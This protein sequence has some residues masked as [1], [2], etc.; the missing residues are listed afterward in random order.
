[1]ELVSKRSIQHSQV[2]AIAA[3]EI[4]IRDALVNGEFETKAYFFNENLKLITEVEGLENKSHRRDI[5]VDE[6]TMFVH[7]D[8]IVPNDVFD[9]VSF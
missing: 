6:E 2:D 4:F 7:Y 8:E 3:R 1:M 9:G 5:L